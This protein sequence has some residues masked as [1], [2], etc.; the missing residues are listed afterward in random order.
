MEDVRQDPDPQ[1]VA[2]EA[3]LEPERQQRHRHLR[4]GDDVVARDHRF[5]VGGDRFVERR[6]ARFLVGGR[7]LRRF[8]GRLQLGAD[9]GEVVRAGTVGFFEGELSALRPGRRSE[10]GA[11]GCCGLEPQAGEIR[12]RAHAGPLSV[13]SGSRSLARI[14]TR[15]GCWKVRR[16]WI[17]AEAPQVIPSICLPCR[18]GGSA[19]AKAA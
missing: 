12:G 16:A 3:R 1:L 8:L 6:R 10:A 17:A 14:A 7:V 13:C 4:G 19:L 9:G 2:V 18:T 15:T 11:V 5:D